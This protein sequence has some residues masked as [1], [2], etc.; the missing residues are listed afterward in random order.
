MGESTLMADNDPILSPTLCPVM[1][2]IWL[3]LSYCAGNILLTRTHTSQAFEP[4][5]VNFRYFARGR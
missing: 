3:G 5:G 1:T 4:S 2:V